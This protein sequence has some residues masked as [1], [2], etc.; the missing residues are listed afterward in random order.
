[1]LSQLQPVAVVIK[2]KALN[3]WYGKFHALKNINLEIKKGEIVV[4]CGPS[5]S[6]GANATANTITFNFSAAIKDESFTVDDIGITNGTIAPSAA[7]VTK[8]LK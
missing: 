6:G 7:A 5:G 8:S 3:K 1:M 4:I 2:I